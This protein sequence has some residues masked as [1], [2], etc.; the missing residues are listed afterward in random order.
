MYFEKDYVNHIYN[1]GNNQQKIFFNDKN[2]IFFLAKIQK[3]IIPNC[4]L[5]AYCLMYNL[6]R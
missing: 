3:Y 1:R 2:Y 5:L 6:I 4:E